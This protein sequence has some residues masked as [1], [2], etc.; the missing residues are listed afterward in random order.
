MLLNSTPQ[1]FYMK[2]YFLTIYV[3]PTDV[4]IV[5]FINLD[6]T[7]FFGQNIG[8]FFGVTNLVKKI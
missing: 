7:Q 8:S 6:K 3:A 1:Q 5:A 4:G 2:F